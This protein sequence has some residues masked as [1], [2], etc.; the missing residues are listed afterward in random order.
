[1]MLCLAILCY[2]ILYA[3]VC[4]PVVL[5]WPCVA[6]FVAGKSV[7]LNELSGFITETPAETGGHKERDDGT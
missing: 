3:V 1:M 4:T 7:S 5:R 6:V 2:P